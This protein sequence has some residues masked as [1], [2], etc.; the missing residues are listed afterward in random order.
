MPPAR[1][2]AVAIRSL[3]LQMRRWHNPRPIGLL[4]RVHNTMVYYS[5]S[6]ARGRLTTDLLV[7]R[8]TFKDAHHFYVRKR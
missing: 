3:S 5:E 7:V 1:Y 8:A 6:T 2:M 4:G